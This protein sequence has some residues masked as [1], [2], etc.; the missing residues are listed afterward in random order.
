MAP[1]LRRSNEDMLACLSTRGL[2]CRRKPWRQNCNRNTCKLEHLRD[3]CKVLERP[4]Q[5]QLPANR[6]GCKESPESLGRGRRT[7]RRERPARR[8]SGRS[9]LAGFGHRGQRQKS[10]GCESRGY[11]ERQGEFKKTT[12][13][14]LSRCG[15]RSERVSTCIVAGMR[16]K[17]GES[18][19]G[20]TRVRQFNSTTQ[21][22]STSGQ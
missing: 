16:R 12:R 20:P 18:Q 4:P 21:R 6:T 10:G 9:D 22:S 1:A 17:T 15:V 11:G 19:S 7:F 14:H 2:P 13:H 3:T 8:S 5:R